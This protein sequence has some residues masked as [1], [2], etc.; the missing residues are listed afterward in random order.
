VAGPIR[1]SILA[2]AGQATKSVTDFATSTEGAVKRSSG[3]LEEGTRKIR[4]SGDDAHAGFSKAGEA[5]DELDTK[6][7]GFRD[8]M[9]GVQDSMRG[10]S[11]IAKGD[12]FNGF[13]TLGMGVGDL[14][15]GLYNFLIPGL[16]GVF[17]NTKVVAAATKVWTGVQ[18]ALNLVMSLN[19]I[20]LVVLAIVALIAII[21]IAYNRS[22]TFRRIVNAAFAGVLAVVRGVL[23]FFQNNWRAILAFMVNP[24]G[25]A[26]GLIRRHSDSILGFFKAIPGAIKG[27]FSGAGSWLSDAGKRIIDGFLGALKAGFDRVKSA[28]GDLTGLLPSWKGPAARD[29]TLLTRNGQLVIQGFQ[30]G[31]ESQYGAVRSSLGG[32]TGSL[33]ASV[34]TAGTI[35]ASTSPTGQQSKLSVALEIERTGDPLLDQLLDLIKDRI[36]VRGGKVQQVLGTGPA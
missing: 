16:K 6:A 23:S 14:G 13:L 7:M 5:A 8:T 33:S 9:T 22:E 18:A 12:L 17:T 21:V 2:D 11:L 15:S 26:V 25:S 29:R 4:Q 36:R 34:G 10:T 35:T 28:L 20:A 1:I 31:L 30:E 27:F 24:V 32:L 19:P 3:A